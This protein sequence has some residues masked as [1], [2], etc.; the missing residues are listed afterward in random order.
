MIVAIYVVF[1]KVVGIDGTFDRFDDATWYWLVVAFCMPLLYYGSYAVL[2]R[3]VFGK[4]GP[5]EFRRRH[6]RARLGLI[7]LAALAASALFSAAGAGG[8]R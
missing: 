5:E 8:S 3:S 4:R 6:R 1:P 2:V 7:T